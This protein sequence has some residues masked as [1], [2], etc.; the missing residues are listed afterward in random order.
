MRK[1]YADLKAA[2]AKYGCDWR[3]AAFTMAV[4]RVGQAALLRGL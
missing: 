2:K 3:T 1:A 4:E